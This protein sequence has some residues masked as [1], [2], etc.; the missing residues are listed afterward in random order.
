[1]NKMLIAI[2][3]VLLI[4]LSIF[5]Y[6]KAV[7]KPASDNAPR[8]RAKIENPAFDFGEIVFG[9][10]A[11][12]TFKLFN[13][14][15][16]PLEIKRVA[17]SCSCTTAEVSKKM[18]EP[19]QSAEISVRYDTKAMGSGPHGVGLQERIIYIKTNDP[20]NPQVEANISAFVK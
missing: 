4:G 3:A 18:I 10:M 16:A 13:N 7:P 2:G 11:T 20:A 17:T 19:G 5:G 8:P 1:M 9:V 14:G 12:H 6:L 15:N